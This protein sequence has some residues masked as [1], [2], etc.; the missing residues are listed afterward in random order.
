MNKKGFALLETLIV[1]VIISGSLITLYY[2][3]NYSVINEN[4]RLYYDDVN[5][6]YKTK[7]H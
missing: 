5:Y 2:A 7:Y 3:Y 1:V 4:I 6:I